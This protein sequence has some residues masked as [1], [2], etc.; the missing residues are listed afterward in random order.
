MSV[1][2]RF[3]LHTSLQRWVDEG[4]LDPDQA[5]RIEARETG[6]TPA[7]LAPSVQQPRVVPPGRGG[8][9]LAYV[10]EALGYLG[11]TLAVIAGFVTVG[12]LW[13]DV[14]TS[15]QLG[16]AAAGAVALAAAGFVVPAHR[17]EAFARLRSVLW[18]LST[19]CVATFAGLLGSQV[20]DLADHTTLLFAAV[21]TAAVACGW[22]LLDRV[23]LQHVAMFAALTLTAVGIVLAAAPDIASWW[24][25]LTAWAFSAV[26]VWCAWRGLVPPRQTGL[27]VAVVGLVVSSQMMMDSAVGTL[28]A[29]GTV[30]GLLTAGVLARQMWLLAAGAVDTLLTVPG[31]AG[32]YLPESLAAPLA[33]FLVG[34][35]L[36]GIALWLARRS[37]QPHSYPR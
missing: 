13:P 5:E 29:L 1:V 8:P 30:A 27:V 25:G 3:D 28:L 15:A 17:N 36:V 4:L 31:A 19:V 32:R 35:V 6:R 11:A 7:P 21:P 34:V 10:V 2:E 14:P 33:V 18:L 20:L 12:E 9:R 37:R 23:A 24:L 16:F 26:W 22:W